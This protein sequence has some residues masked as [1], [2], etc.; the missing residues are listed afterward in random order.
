[1]DGQPIDCEYAAMQNPTVKWF[2]N[3]GNPSTLPQKAPDIWILSRKTD[4]V[5]DIRTVF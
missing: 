3:G 1:M 2:L 4:G 5:I